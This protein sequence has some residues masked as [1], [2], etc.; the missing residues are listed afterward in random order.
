MRLRV[1]IV[2]PSLQQMYGGQEVMGRQLVDGWHRS[3]AVQATL[4]E[5]NPRLTGF[6]GHAER[7]PFVRTLLRMPARLTHLQ[8]GIKRSDVVH[9]FSGAHTSF[10]L[11]SLPAIV[12]GWMSR[13]PVLA[14]YHSPR[15]SAHLERSALARFV[16]R[17][18][19]AVVVPS[20]YLQ[21]VFGRH[22][23][24]ARIIP[25]VVDSERFNWRDIPRPEYTVLCIRN[26]EPRYG[27]DDVIRAFAEVKR[28]MP[29]AVLLLVGAGPEA[30][31]LG[32]LVSELGVADV[33]FAGAL[34]RDDLAAL[35]QT[36]AVLINA[37]REDNMPL[38]I[39]E[40][41]A[42]GVPVATTSAGGITTFVRHMQNALVS[43]PGN[44]ETL[45][46]H[47]V[48]LL[49]DTPLATRLTSNAR[50]DA[51]LFTWEAVRPAWEALYAELHAGRER[52]RR[53]DRTRA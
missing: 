34:G 5:S 11:G 33:T 53:R 22:G 24:A 20:P 31:R 13:R 18:C 46:R 45:A 4:L 1:S 30:Q 48:M 2:A 7:I 27:V 16:F 38:T 21:E 44:V 25:N 35:M 37:S 15:A 29:N 41:F 3:A 8:R 6:L 36:A 17:K 47:V 23:V 32:T 42:S 14:H 39:L 50:A 19:D 52:D 49:L 40:A 26:F 10:I 12:V 28:R 9:V 43:E 51:R